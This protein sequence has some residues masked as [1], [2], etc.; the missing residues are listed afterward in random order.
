MT[1]CRRGT[2]RDPYGLTLS[3]IRGVKEQTLR[4]REKGNTGKGS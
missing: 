4:R 1:L 2:R 3:E